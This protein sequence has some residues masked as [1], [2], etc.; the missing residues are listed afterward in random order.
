MARGSD[1]KQPPSTPPLFSHHLN[2]A[3]RSALVS[4]WNFPRFLGPCIAA[5]SSTMLLVSPLSTH[6]SD[7][8]TSA[9]ATRL[10]GPLAPRRLNYAWSVFVAA[11]FS[12]PSLID[13]L[14]PE[15]VAQIFLHRAGDPRLIWFLSLR[16]PFVTPRISMPTRMEAVQHAWSTKNANPRLAFSAV[17]LSYTT[18]PPLSWKQAA[19]LV[20]LLSL[21]SNLL[22]TL[23]S[24]LPLP[25][26]NPKLTPNC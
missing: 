21:S 9:L 2:G 4:A 7:M 11:P 6:A 5:P 26:C 24:N 16:S 8:L 23:P 3:L 18:T 12:V 19:G 1:K 17:A 13:R 10:S 25:I 22:P 14:S 20:A 15:Q